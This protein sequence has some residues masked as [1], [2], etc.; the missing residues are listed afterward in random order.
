MK[1]F[2]IIAA[3]A[4]TASVSSCAKVHTCTCTENTDDVRSYTTHVVTGPKSHTPS[5]REAKLECEEVGPANF[6]DNATNYS[7]GWKTSC[8]FK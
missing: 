5:K 1:I 3:V 7:Y 4:L 6:N 8:E 2:T